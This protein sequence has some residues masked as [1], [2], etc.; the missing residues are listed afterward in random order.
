ML[1]IGN[2]SA[3][4]AGILVLALAALVVTETAV[5][6]TTLSKKGGPVTKVK[7]VTADDAPVTTSTSF[8][9]VP[10]M[11]VSMSVP[12]GQTALFV[13]TLS[14][15]STCYISAAIESAL[16]YVRL[17]VDNNPAPPGDLVFIS[18]AS[19]AG[20][21]SMQFV[22]GPLS[23]GP[24]TVQVQWLVDHEGATFQMAERTLTVLR[25]NI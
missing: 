13:V 2:P 1:L 5:L 16:C 15:V 19:G 25:S 11:S 12:S 14:A 23:A 21:H 3:R 9:N 24:H 22:A 8:S 7:T 6:A 17:L 18:Y 4:L 20:A 10:G